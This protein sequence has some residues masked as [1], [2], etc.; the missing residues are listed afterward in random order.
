[1]NHTTIAKKLGVTQQAVSLWFAGKTMPS[2][3]NLLALA[4]VLGLS[5]EKTIVLLKKPQQ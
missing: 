2:T 4:K 1:M 3:K 5:V